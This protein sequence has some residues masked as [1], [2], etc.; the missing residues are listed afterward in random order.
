MKKWRLAVP[1]IVVFLS[2][3]FSK[4][5]SMNLSA[6]QPWIADDFSRGAGI[7]LAL[8]SGTITL[9]MWFAQ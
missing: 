7:V 6:A 8:L 4:L 3:W 9:L 1:M 2:P 5:V